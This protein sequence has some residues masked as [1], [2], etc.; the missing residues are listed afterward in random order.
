M[1]E[2]SSVI[3]LKFVSSSELAPSSSISIAASTASKKVI[4]LLAFFHFSL[5]ARFESRNEPSD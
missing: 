2:F 4:Y 5:D 3:V 1:G